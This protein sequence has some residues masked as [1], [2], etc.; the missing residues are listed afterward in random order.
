[1][2]PPAPVTRSAVARAQ[3]GGDQGSDG[4]H[5]GQRQAGE[6]E[7]VVEVVAG[8]RPH[9]RALVERHELGVGAGQPEHVAQAEHVVARRRTP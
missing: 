2:A 1:M 3:A 6:A 8:R 7:E 9:D 5:T 4:G